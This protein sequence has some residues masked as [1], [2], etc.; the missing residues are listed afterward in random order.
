MINRLSDVQRTLLRLL[1]NSLF[2]APPPD[3]LGDPAALWREANI[4]GVFLLAL[5]NAD[6]SP[7]PPE[8]Q[9]E[10]HDSVRSYLTGNLRIARGHAELSGLLERSG[11]PHVIIKGFA[12][13]LWYPAPELRLMGDVDFFVDRQ[14]VERTEALLLREGYEPEK[15]S[16][17]FHHVFRKEGCRY[18][19][20]FEIP[21]IPEGN[22]GD[23][24]R[25]CFRDLLERSSVR[26]TPFGEMRMP[27]AY[28]HGLVLLLHTAHHLTYSGIGLRHVC[29]WAVFV[30]TLPEEDFLADY[31]DLLKALGLWRFACCLTD[32]CVRYL[33]V[34]PKSW[35][36]EADRELSDALLTDIF[37]A[38]NF[39][40]KNVVRTREAHLITSGR[41]YRSRI[42]RFFSVM[43]DM[44]YQKWPVSKKIKLLAPVGWAYYTLR[45]L[46]RA[47]MGKRPKPYVREALR[48]A[49]ERTGLYDRFRLFDDTKE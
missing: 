45:Y 7:F 35:T 1:A 36:Q 21:G 25:A 6:V 18:E 10:L 27:A 19:L 29:D 28:H 39:G 40:Q 42:R 46:W 22:A 5:Q 43:L 47:A 26:H 33:G 16:H 11:I 23:A 24:C 44:I 12:C 48:G 49:Q 2:G 9:K 4:Q 17:G 15:L 13:S 3:G 41:K 32:I 20:H 34:T 14:D 38:G 37:E 8:A 30:E 31:G